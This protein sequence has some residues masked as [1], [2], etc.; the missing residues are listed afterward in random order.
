MGYRC[1]CVHATRPHAP[2]PTPPTLQLLAHPLTQA[3]MQRVAAAM[4]VSTTFATPLGTSIARPSAQYACTDVVQ[5]C[6]VAFAVVPLVLLSWVEH[7]KGGAGGVARPAAELR[8]VQQHAGPPHQAR[9]LL[10]LAK[11]AWHA[12]PRSVYLACGCGLSWPQ[13]AA[14]LAWLLSMLWLLTTF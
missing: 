10:V 6:Q 14:L 5:F 9:L 2:P 11:R 1:A 4:H 8:A 13:R 12:A 3:R 7:V